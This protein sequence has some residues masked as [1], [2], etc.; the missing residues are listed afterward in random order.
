VLPI[1]QTRMMLDSMGDH[2]RNPVVDQLFAAC[3]PDRVVA[4]VTYLASSA[5]DVSHQLI[6][7]VAGR[8]ARVFLGLGEG[9]LADRSSEPTAEDVAE[10]LASITATEPF[11]V[12]MSV[13]DEIVTM[14]SRL[15]I[16]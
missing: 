6:S 2:D 7:A 10:H 9:W 8:Y 1:G 13:A 11:T 14:L 16:I 12:P 5:C 4:I 3:T 15:E